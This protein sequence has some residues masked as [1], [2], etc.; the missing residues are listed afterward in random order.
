VAAAL[1]A[2]LLVLAAAPAA[3]AA[4]RL[5][6][7]EALA[8]ATAP[9][10]LRQA[11]DDHPGARW[12]ATYDDRGGRWRA[13]L[14]ED[15]ETFAS[16]VLDDRS[17]ELLRIQ[18]G[19]G[20]PRLEEGEAGRLAARRPEVREWLALY[21]T[22]DRRE[23]L[24]DDRVWTVTW[25]SGGRDI[26]EVR[27]SDRFG[28]IEDVRTGPQVDWML[29][30]GRPSSYGRKVA[31]W[32]IFVPLCAL[33][34]AGLVNWRR[35]FSMRTLDLLAMLAFGVSLIWFNR[36]D[37][38][39]A[40]PLVYP[41]LL[42][43]LARM[44]HVARS[45][46]PRTV[47]IGSRHA[48]VLVAL[49]FGLMGFRLGLNNQDSNVIDVGYAGVV[50]ADR[51]L[52]GRLPYGNMPVETNRPC[53]GRYDDGDPIGYVQT[54]SGRCESVTGGIDTYGPAV[55]VA[56]MPAVAIM[57]WSGRW[58]TVPAAHLAAGAF[59]VLALVGLFLAGLRLGGGRLGVLLAFAWAANPFTAYTLNMNA[60]DALVGAALAWALAALSFPSVR[61]ALLAIAALTKFAP[62]LLVPLFASLPRRFATLASFAAASIALLAMLALEPDGL[63]RFY[64][65]TVGYQLD[66]V[67]PM[68]IWTIGEFRPGWP[69]LG[70]TQRA[71][72]ILV[73]LGALAAA[74]LP[75][76]RRDVATVAALSAAL[77]IG[78]QLA[79]SYW[80]YPYICWWLPPLLVALFAPRRD[81]R[82]FPPRWSAGTA[83]GLDRRGAPVG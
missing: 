9:A 32:W 60:N 19:P 35:P 33:F 80:F 74:F 2:L 70:P 67:T 56:Y 52:D 30:R 43:L 40:T 77:V 8:A 55:Y 34:L 47:H 6:T 72:Q 50:G 44:V 81:D 75:R 26:A 28:R 38:F 15:G 4:A 1:L 61:G 14:V 49:T 83:E 18:P 29:A 54:T 12:Q 31:E 25:S 27:L 51:L 17:G 68:S 59:D 13:R 57:G 16:V 20:P 5:S 36:G 65:A 39:V 23:I 21:P 3:A 45:A 42:Y 7:D 22:R 64:D 78:S 66:R 48:L 41:P 53:G 37:L 79:A 71:V 62:F 10:V 58:D 63:R 73:V 69:D 82:A 76:R 24:G 11:E 46:R